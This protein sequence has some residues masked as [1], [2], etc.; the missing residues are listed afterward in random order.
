MASANTA[1]IFVANVTGKGATW[2]NSDAANTKKV[3]SPTIGA[4]GARIHFINATSSDTSARD[5]N[6]Y[7]NDGTTDFLIGAFTVTV[8][9]GTSGAI[10][11]V[12][13]S[14]LNTQLPFLASDGSLLI[15][16][17][18]SLK[19][20]NAAQVTSAKSVAITV[21]GGDY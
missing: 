1:P 4:N 19:A 7:L 10:A 13:V 18:W 3:I 2:T 21:I 6:L 14:A 11:S 15:P 8:G 12:C 17:G 20:E 16:A 9:A 5:F